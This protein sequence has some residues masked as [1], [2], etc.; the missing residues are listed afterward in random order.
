MVTLAFLSDVSDGIVARRLGLATTDLRFADSVVDAIFYLAA[1]AAVFLRA[2]TALREVA[3]PLVV[4]VA[5]EL[6][7][8]ILEYATFGRMAAYHMWSAKAWGVALWLGFAEV[9][10]IQRAGP[11]FHL[12]VWLGIVAD[13]EGLAAS[14]LLSTRQSDVPTLR[15][16]LERERAQA[17]TTAAPDRPERDSLIND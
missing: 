5:L 13:V 4:L 14:I 17:L 15:H 12:A 3:V 8:L 9:F 2:P 16:A 6:S 10:L 11:F 1:L 7:R